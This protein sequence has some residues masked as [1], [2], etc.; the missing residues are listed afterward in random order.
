MKVLFPIE[1]IV[2]LGGANNVLKIY[3]KDKIDHWISEIDSSN[4][5]L[6]L[7]HLTICNP[8]CGEWGAYHSFNNSEISNWLRENGF[9]VNDSFVFT[10]ILDVYGKL[11]LVLSE[12]NK[13]YLGS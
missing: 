13:S 1:A 11:H 9:T 2:K 5:I 3:F 8:T 7:G 4:I 10:G 12:I 6:H